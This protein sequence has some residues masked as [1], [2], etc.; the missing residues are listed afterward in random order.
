MNLW[1]VASSLGGFSNRFQSAACTVSRF[2]IE[3]RNANASLQIGKLPTI[4]EA[5]ILD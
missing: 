4:F 2:K 1:S 5:A 3:T